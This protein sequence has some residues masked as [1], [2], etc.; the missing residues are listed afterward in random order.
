MRRLGGSE[1]ERTVVSD[2]VLLIYTNECHVKSCASLV[3]NV[4]H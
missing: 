4:N 2:K 3:N 1:S